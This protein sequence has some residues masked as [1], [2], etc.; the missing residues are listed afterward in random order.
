MSTSVS[1]SPIG[2]NVFKKVVTPAQAILGVG[3]NDVPPSSGWSTKNIILEDPIEVALAG[4]LQILY[5]AHVAASTSHAY[6]GP[7][8]AFVLWCD[9]LF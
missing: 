9:K 6:V 7:W 2:I 3:N 1:C 4:E 5:L 8:N